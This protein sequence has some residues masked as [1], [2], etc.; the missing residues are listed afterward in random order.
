MTT[1][2][3]AQAV[4]YF[5]NFRGVAA[6]HLLNIKKKNC[7]K[8]R[9][10]QSPVTSHQSPV[11][12]KYHLATLADLPTWRRLREELYDDL[13]P[14]H[15]ETEI[16]RIAEDPD[17]ATYF[18][19]D[20]TETAPT[21]ML[22]LS[23]RNIVDG[24]LSSPVAYID[25]LYVI[26]KWQGRAWVRNWLILPNNGHGNKAAPNW[27]WTRNWTMNGRSVFTG[28]QGLRRRSGW[29]ST[30]WGYKSMCLLAQGLSIKTQHC[31]VSI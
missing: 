12:M 8:S 26:E 4:V 21:G 9:S 27:L 6:S 13:D 7:Q 16:R 23:L 17:L 24:C 1:R 10:P 30:G 2:N 18:V 5:L 31:W 22:E 28:K 11:T 29:C 19:F 14:A 20:E 25:G 3:F 15:S